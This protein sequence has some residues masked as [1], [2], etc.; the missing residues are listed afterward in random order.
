MCGIVALGVGAYWAY[1]LFMR[2][3]KTMTIAWV[4]GILAIIGVI[5]LLVTSSI[6]IVIDKPQRQITFRRKRIMGA[7]TNSYHTS[8]VIRVELRR[9]SYFNHEPT[10]RQGFSMGDDHQVFDSQSI[11]MFKDGTE[12][13]LEN[14]KS[15]NTGKSPISTGVMMAG[16]GK[17]L[18]ISRQVAAFLSVPFQEI[19]SG[20]TNSSPQDGIQL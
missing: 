9:N 11:I 2:P 16:E 5:M 13:P 17:E 12:L 10:S 20:G 3:G 19:G 15:R 7:K 8:D 4:L 18:S 6:S 14:R 1:S